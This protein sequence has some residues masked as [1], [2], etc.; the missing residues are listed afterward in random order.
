MQHF[1]DYNVEHLTKKKK[2]ENW[3]NLQQYPYPVVF[4]KVSV[5]C[6]NSIISDIFSLIK[7][8]SMSKIDTKKGLKK[9]NFKV[10]GKNG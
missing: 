8:Q 2:K 10:K 6:S 7:W 1:A 9:I 4:W 5:S 3:Y